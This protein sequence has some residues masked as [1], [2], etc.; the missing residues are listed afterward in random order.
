MFLPL[1]SPLSAGP[2]LLSALLLA[3]SRGLVGTGFLGDLALPA[4]PLCDSFSPEL[5]QPG[6]VAVS[7]L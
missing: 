4:L 7:L 3:V 1:T 2:T 5:L 6:G